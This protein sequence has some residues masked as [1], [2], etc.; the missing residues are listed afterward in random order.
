MAEQ[1]CIYS[2]IKAYSL[3]EYYAV[4]KIIES[5]KILMM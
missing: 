5:I 3:G 4:E 2:L 1:I